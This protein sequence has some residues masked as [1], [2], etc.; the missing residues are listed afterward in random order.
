[1][2]WLDGPLLRGDLFCSG[3]L[4]CGSDVAFGVGEASEFGA[5]PI[6][7]IKVEFLA[8]QHQ[9]AAAYAWSAVGGGE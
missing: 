7:M 4:G 6:I 9:L 5:V 3:F 8:W 2:Y 1:V